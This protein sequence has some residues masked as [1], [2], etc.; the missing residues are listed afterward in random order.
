MGPPA[1]TGNRTEGDHEHEGDD[2]LHLPRL[3]SIH[4]HE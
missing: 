2:H 1:R 4:V 3:P